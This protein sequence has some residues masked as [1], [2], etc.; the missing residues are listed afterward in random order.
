MDDIMVSICVLSYNHEKYLRDCLDGIV[1][2]KTTFPIEAWV[3]DDAST[4]GSAAI[5]REYAEKYPAII[6]PILQTENQY[7]KNKRILARFV[8][9]RCVGRYI[10]SCEGDDY[11]ID[12]YKLQKQVDFMENHPEIGLC[13]TDYNQQCDQGAIVPSMYEKQ[14]NY[15][16]DTY[17]QHL[18]KPG[19]LAPMTWVF[20]RVLLS[21]FMQSNVVSDGSY[22]YMLEFMHNSKVAYIPEVTATYRV[23]P[24]SASRPA[25]LERQWQ[26]VFGVMQTQLEYAQKFG[27]ESLVEKVYL[28][29][30]L[31]DVLPLA[32]K[33]GKSEFIE[34]AKTFLND[35]GININE[36]IE[37][38]ETYQ[39]IE[40]KYNKIRASQ[41][42][43][44]GTML[45]TPYQ[46]MRSFLRKIWAK[47]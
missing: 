38:I 23:H 28:N 12:P 29:N 47:K 5:I 39:D 46:M 24:N 30:Y 36:Q 19:Y 33:L 6:K 18:L 4:D 9:P 45:F 34:E 22:A 11:W 27:N 40:N 37:L 25:T 14:H 1:M 42:Y 15:R 35:I 3:H 10:A 16:P 21:Y 17:E 2:Q 41:A 13:Y 44:I 32:I 7:S 43:K 20:R 8:Y 31:I 26:Y